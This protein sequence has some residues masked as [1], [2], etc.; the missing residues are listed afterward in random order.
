MIAVPVLLSGFTS[1]D[2]DERCLNQR[3]DTALSLTA[4]LS[5]NIPAA[6]SLRDNESVFHAA[7]IY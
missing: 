2:K 6:V 4:E 1:E 3:A 5:V 7:P